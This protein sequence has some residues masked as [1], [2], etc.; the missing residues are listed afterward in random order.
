MAK[1][2]LITGGSQGSR[3][4]NQ[5]AEAS[6]P[7]WSTSGVQVHLIHQTG[8]DHRV[9]PRLDTTPEHRPIPRQGDL[10]N[11]RRRIRI[12]AGSVR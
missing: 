12:D 2:M 11:R 1:T 7:L 3:T 9:H 5:A 6:W 10:S 8:L 4:L